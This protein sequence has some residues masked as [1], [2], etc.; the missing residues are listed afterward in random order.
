MAAPARIARIVSG[1]QTGVDRA[2]LD[3]ARALGITTGGWCPAG[4]WAEDLTVEPGVR[5]MF[6]EL[7]ETPEADPA[8]RTAWNVRDS[9]A[10]LVR[11][12][13]G[14]TS[15]G[16][17]LTIADAED[18]GRSHLVADVA[19]VSVVRTWLDRLPDGTVLN[20]AGPRESEAPGIAA[21]AAD[22]LRRVLSG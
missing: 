1:G 11:V 14:A 5:T 6:P 12:R 10:T 8:Q 19:E 4:G 2:A 22:L 18:L 9:D 16:T 17:V 7:V 3:T 20:V 15:P 21:E 13:R